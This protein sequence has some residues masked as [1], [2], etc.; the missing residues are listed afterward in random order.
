VTGLLTARE[1]A[2]RLGVTTETVLVWVRRG[3]LPAF[4]LPG[5]AIRFRPDEFEAW[6]AERATP[7]RGAPA[8]T[9]D[10][11]VLTLPS[12]PPATTHEE[13]R[14]RRKGAVVSACP[15]DCRV[16]QSGDQYGCIDSRRLGRWV[17]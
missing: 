17:P 2:E 9:P 5:G 13:Q 1:V 7:G 10:A 11:A 16:G 6:L 14:A 8:T 15:F 4:R 3:E 12:S